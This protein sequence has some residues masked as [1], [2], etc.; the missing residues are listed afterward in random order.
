MIRDWKKGKH[1]LYEEWDEEHPVHL[2][3]HSQGAPT[4]RKLQELL[5][6]QF[7][8]DTE[9]GETYPTNDRWIKSITAI[10]GVN[11]GALATYL[12]GCDPGS[13][14]VIKNSTA[15]H[16]AKTLKSVSERE[17]KDFTWE[18]FNKYI[19]NLD[20][21]QWRNAHNRINFE[22][23]IEG[24]DNCVYDLTLHGMQ[25]FNADSEDYPNTYYFSYL[26]SQT[27]AAEDTTGHHH[28]AKYLM[29]PV[30]QSTADGIGEYPCSEREVLTHLRQGIEDY[31][32]WWENDG[33][34]SVCSQAYPR[35]P[36]RAQ[37][38]TQ[39][40]FYLPDDELKPGVWYV[41]KKLEMDH[42]DIVMFPES[43]EQVH[44]QLEFY[45]ELYRLLAQL[46]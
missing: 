12:L 32:E 31:S 7:F 38:K 21:E 5:N 29:N 36:R 22:D 3:G 18:F 42:L 17:L 1:P 9:T 44:R 19:Y 6:K 15:W 30:L 39:H 20:L 8:I 45:S 46:D 13:G 14:L 4:I 23:F 25:A 43:P 33:L 24:E 2:I 10:S 34:V 37:Y 41:M 16:L 27:K 40:Q 11:N 28:V 26:T 35:D